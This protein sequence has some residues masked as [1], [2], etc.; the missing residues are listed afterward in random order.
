MFVTVF[1][2][3]RCAQLFRHGAVTK[4]MAGYKKENL[5]RARRLAVVISLA[6]SLSFVAGGCESGTGA[7]TTGGDSPD[8][9][10]PD[11]QQPIQKAKNAANQ[12]SQQQKQT[13]DNM[14]QIMQS[15]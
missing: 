10:V 3:R 5:Q 2:Y 14:S 4:R 1:N 11:Y 13:E 9:L 8:S 6:V 15:P 7:G 12:T